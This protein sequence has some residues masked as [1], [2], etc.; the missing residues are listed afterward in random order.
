M[1]SSSQPKH[2]DHKQKPHD[3]TAETQPRHC[4]ID[5]IEHQHAS[6]ATQRADTTC[7]GGM[8]ERSRAGRRRHDACVTPTEL[9]GHRRY[10]LRTG[11][12]I[13]VV[14]QHSTTECNPNP[15]WVR[16]PE[17]WA[18]LE[19]ARRTPTPATPKD[20]DRIR[21]EGQTTDKGKLPPP[22]PR[23]T[24]HRREDRIHCRHL[25]NHGAHQYETDSKTVVAQ[26]PATTTPHVGSTSPPWPPSAKP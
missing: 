26:H 4:T 19:H 5:V 18:S 11:G 7:A 12:I 9:E 8:S 23:L 21:R 15:I 10:P 1:S 20:F 24:S 13:A 22:L 14:A 6:E 25:Q 2:C 17:G 16:L 3:M